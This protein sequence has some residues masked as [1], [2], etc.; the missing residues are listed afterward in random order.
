M[1]LKIYLNTNLKYCL[2]QIKMNLVLLDFRTLTLHKR[3]KMLVK[4]T[5]KFCCT[6][7]Y[8]INVK[9]C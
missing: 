5:L 2:S 7:I 4:L 1:L 6:N 8:Y 3:R 9:M